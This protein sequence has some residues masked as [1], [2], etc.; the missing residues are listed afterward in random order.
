MTRFGFY[1]P[2]SSDA[3]TNG[4]KADL[5]NVVTAAIRSCRTSIDQWRTSLEPW[6]DFVESVRRNWGDGTLTY[7]LAAIAAGMVSKGTRATG[8]DDLLDEN[9]PLV[10]RARCAKLKTP[11]N[12]WRRAL[13]DA[14][15]DNIKI[16]VFILLLS[17]APGSVIKGLKTDLTTALMELDDNGWCDLLSSVRSVVSSTAQGR[18]P[19][20]GLDEGAFLAITSPRLKALLTLR[21]PRSLSFRGLTDLL[22]GY[23]GNDPHLGAFLTRAGYERSA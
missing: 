14:S 11:V 5:H 12:W 21:L 16:W 7:C 15:T 19:I 22:D 4:E 6:S 18:Q 9:L 2:S 8:F 20:S 17:W 13:A 1:F 3:D 10:E 23:D